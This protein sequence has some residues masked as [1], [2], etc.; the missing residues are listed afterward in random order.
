MVAYDALELELEKLRGEVAR[1]NTTALRRVLD[2]V[3]EVVAD[4]SR[5]ADERMNWLKSFLA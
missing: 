2:V 3:E 5:P 1:D 4:N